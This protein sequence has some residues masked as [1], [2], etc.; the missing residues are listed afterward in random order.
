[1]K[2]LTTFILLLVG[3]APAAPAQ[4]ADRGG[5]LG[6]PVELDSSDVRYRE[7][8][9][10]VK[11][12]IDERLT[13]SNLITASSTGLPIRAQFTF[14]HR[15]RGESATIIQAAPLN[16]A[17]ISGFTLVSLFIAAIAV[18]WAVTLWRGI[19]LWRQQRRDSPATRA[20][21]TLSEPHRDDAGNVDHSVIA[22]SVIAHDVLLSHGWQDDGDRTLHGLAT[23]SA[24]SY[25]HPELRGHRVNVAATGEWEHT[26]VPGM[27][28]RGAT[29]DELAQHLGAIHGTLSIADLH[30]PGR[31][32]S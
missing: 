8:L 4:G 31:R 27:P 23:P 19:T 29:A 14:M 15:R 1:M 17:P 25:S 13:P 20:G 28:A 16:G 26:T 24:R 22:Q 18:V 6:K 21:D 7:Y 32:K 12:R 3:M 5:I 2:I 10:T 30:L 9:D 11:R